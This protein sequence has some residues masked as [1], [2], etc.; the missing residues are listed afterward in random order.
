MRTPSSLRL[1]PTCWLWH[2]LSP[3]TPAAQQFRRAVNHP[4]PLLLFP[5]C[6]AG[7]MNLRVELLARTFSC[8]RRS[9]QGLTATSGG[10]VEIMQAL[11]GNDFGATSATRGGSGEGTVEQAGREH[12]RENEATILYYGRGLKTSWA[13]A[14]FF[15]LRRGWQEL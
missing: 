6:S 9:I 11:Q 10:D 3:S 8:T 14:R 15:F 5:G 7:T 13:C 12:L 1:R 2:P 4:S